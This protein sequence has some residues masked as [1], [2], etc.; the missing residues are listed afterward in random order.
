MTKLKTHEQLLLSD[1]PEEAAQSLQ[2]IYSNFDALWCTEEKKRD[3]KQVLSVT[4]KNPNEDVKK[5]RKQV[6]KKV[7]EKIKEDGIVK[8]ISFEKLFE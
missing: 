8:G 3:I 7:V 4:K 2:E 1:S 6:I 5:A